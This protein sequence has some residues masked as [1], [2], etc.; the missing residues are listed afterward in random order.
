MTDEGGITHN[1]TI[2]PSDPSVDDIVCIRDNSNENWIMARITR[3][4]DAGLY[5]LVDPD[6]STIT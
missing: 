2:K 4:P 3:I 1:L 5:Q 6:T